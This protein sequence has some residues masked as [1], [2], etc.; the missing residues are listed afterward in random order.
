MRN[1]LATLATPTL[2]AVRLLSR[3]WTLSILSVSQSWVS[4]GLPHRQPAM[5]SLAFLASL[6]IG[7]VAFRAMDSNIQATS[8]PLPQHEILY[9][10]TPP[11]QPLMSKLAPLSVEIIASEAQPTE[12]PARTPRP[13]LKVTA[14]RREQSSSPTVPSVE[15]IVTPVTSVS[16]DSPLFE[17]LSDANLIPVPNTAASAVPVTLDVE[18]P[19]SPLYLHGRRKHFLKSHDVMIAVG[20]RIEL[21][22]Q[23]DPSYK[24]SVDIGSAMVSC[25]PAEQVCTFSAVGSHKV[26]SL[27]VGR[28][29]IQALQQRLDTQEPTAAEEAK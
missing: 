16:D 11:E 1:R 27:R 5:V 10:P 25:N 19:Q 28:R 7:A 20:E 9:T 26:L 12:A 15:N 29:E 23:D 13:P 3:C 21:T 8:K 4:N 17:S 24:F 14:Y 2:G 6:A 22:E 18:G